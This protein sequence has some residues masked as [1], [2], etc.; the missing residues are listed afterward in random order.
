MPKTRRENGVNAALPGAF[1]GACDS[2]LALRRERPVHRRIATLATEGYTNKEIAE[3]VGREAPYVSHILR[4]PFVQKAMIETIS[5]DTQTAMK[6]A[7]E[8]AAPGCLER[9][10]SVATDEVLK[11]KDPK[12]YAAV[13]QDLFSRFMGKAAQPLD[14]RQ[15]VNPKELTDEQLLA[16]ATGSSVSLPPA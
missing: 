4:Q 1:H 12:T 5:K 11:A 7:L 3:V 10:L 13:N 15:S 8:K 9:L 16:I 2:H 6:E 14:V